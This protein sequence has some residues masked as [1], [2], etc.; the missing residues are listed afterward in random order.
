MKLWDLH[1]HTAG[2]SLCSRVPA[3]RLVEI[4]RQD[5]I[6]G[7]VLTNHYKSAHVQGD[8]AGWRERYVEEYYRT[9]EWGEKAG[10]AV[11]FGVEVTPDCMPQ[12]DFTIYGLTEQDVL[13]AEP[14]FA[15][16]LPELSAFAR[17]RG[18]LIFHAHP[19]RRTTPV[20]AQFVDGV[21]INCHPLYRTCE[22]ERVRAFAEEHGL[23]LSCGSDYH[24]DTYK[25]RC[26][27]WLPESVTDIPGLVAFLRDNPRPAMV[28]APD[29]AEGA[30]VGPGE[31]GECGI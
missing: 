10:L 18:A 7:I 26:G 19:Y 16:S 28:I 9:R 24:G 6:D 31:G 1:T 22:E 23:L 3:E 2:I 25:A 4:Y 12:N 8:F 14:L 13:E 17:E 5:H 29:P 15:L 27:V 30:P 21:E 11:L 20:E